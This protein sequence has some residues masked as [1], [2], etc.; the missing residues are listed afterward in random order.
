M[1]TK[2]DIK[3]MQ[4]VTS[5]EVAWRDDV[6]VKEFD[7]KQ[8]ARRI[9]VYRAYSPNHARSLTYTEEFVVGPRGAIK[10]IHKGQY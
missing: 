5:L 6:T 9:Y 10:Q 1:P 7:V 8:V 3:Q 2:N 4:A